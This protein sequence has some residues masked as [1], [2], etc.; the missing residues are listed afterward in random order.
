MKNH[1]ILD[2]QWCKGEKCRAQ[3]ALKNEAFKLVA[4][5]GIDTVENELETKNEANKL[6]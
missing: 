2:C 6:P 1:K 5:I 4:K 3:K